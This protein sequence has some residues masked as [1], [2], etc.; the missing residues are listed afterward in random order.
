MRA[1]CGSP[2]GRATRRA[3][4]NKALQLTGH[5]GSNP[6]VSRLAAGWRARP[7]AGRSTSGVDWPRSFGA[8]PARSRGRQ[9]NADPLGSAP[10]PWHSQAVQEQ[11]GREL[12]SLEPGLIDFA[13]SL[14]T[15]LGVAVSILFAT[16]A[17]LGVYLVSFR[18]ASIYKIDE[19]K[20]PVGSLFRVIGMLVSL[21]LSLAFAEVVVALRTVE[22]AIQREVV[23]ISDT[24]SDLRSFDEAE[25]RPIQ[26][27]VI[28]YSDLVARDE[29]P[30]LA[31]DRLGDRTTILKRQLANAVMNL[32][33]TTPAQEKLWSNILADVDAISDNR[34]IRLNGAL[35][36]P[37][38][39]INVVFFGFLVTMACF[40]AYRPQVPLVALVSLYTAFVGLV[41]Y[42]IVSLSD[43]FHGAMGLGPEPFEQ[44]V[45]AMQSE[46]R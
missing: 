30:A 19:L 34:L 6:P 1:D 45:V 46:A 27:L 29:W 4:P 44:L 40:G 38:V 26:Q 32:E 10:G 17:G 43:P 33:P 12:H 23:A 18:L 3:P 31:N 36:E 42:L 15:W 24:F 14:P 25:T 35:A 22:N 11:A 20:D 28:D 7:G 37:P 21:M 41:L 16:V 9:L 13:I 39:Y 5:S 8:R 2:T